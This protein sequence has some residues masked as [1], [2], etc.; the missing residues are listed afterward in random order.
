M[1]VRIS[2]RSIKSISSSSIISITFLYNLLEFCNVKP[3]LNLEY[4]GI[5]KKYNFALFSIDKSLEYFNIFL[6]LGS[7][8]LKYFSKVKFLICTNV[9]KCFKLNL[10]LL[11]FLFNLVFLNKKSW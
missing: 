8:L 6:K 2:F 1:L 5:Y 11:S 3:F 9:M 4:S 7:I 10:N